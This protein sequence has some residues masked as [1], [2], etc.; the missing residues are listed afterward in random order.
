MKRIKTKIK[1]KH[2]IISIIGLAFLS[3]IASSIYSSYRENV[4][5]LENH[6]L[7]MNKVFAKKFAQMIDIF[8]DDSM[9][10]LAFISSNVADSMGNNQY[11]LDEVERLLKENKMFNSVI[12]ANEKGEIIAS[13][14]GNQLKG[15]KIEST[16]GL[17]ILKSQK[18]NIS[19]IYKSNTANTGKMLITISYP[20]FSKDGEYKGVINGTVYIYDKNFF[21]SVL[22]D[23]IVLSENNYRDVS[24][25]YIVDSKGKIIY[26]QKKDWIGKDVSKNEAVKRVVKGES[27]SLRIKNTAGEEMLT[28]FSYI[29]LAGWGIVTQTPY[30]T[31]TKTAGK[32]VNHMLLIELPLIFISMIVVV[33]ITQQVVKPLQDIAKIAEN[34]TDKSELK[35][36][37]QLNVWYYEVRKIKTSLL[38]SLSFLHKQVSYFKDESTHDPLTQL[39]NRRS[40]DSI[41]YSWITQGKPFSMV[42]LDIDFFKS[43]NDTYGHTVGDEILVYFTKGMQK[44]TREQDVLCRFGGEEFIILLP[45]TTVKEAYEIIEGFRLKMEN[46]KSP[47]GKQLTFSGG[48]THFPE[49]KEVHELIESADAALYKAKKHGRNHIVIAKEV[50]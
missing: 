15:S 13:A 1:L 34:S 29:K 27:G 7:E 3:S 2:L 35:K 37:R 33:F 47:T 18:P 6:S 32:E 25:V 10:K 50:K 43:V 16:E 24:N 41:L 9:E 36:L 39:F 26:H 14:P 21:N 11:L 49:V 22:G 4:K 42:L 31:A 5:L 12:I 23:N 8:L 30:E 48:I 20:I 44:I 28:G 38:Q 19:D 40:L 17:R 46:T 45:E